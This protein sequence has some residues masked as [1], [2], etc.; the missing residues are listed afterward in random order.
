MASVSL[1]QPAEASPTRTEFRALVALALPLA[2]A[3]LIQMMVYAV[4]VIFVARLGAENL[5]ASSLS[6]SLFGLLMWSMTGLVGAAA[7]LI[8]AELGRRRHAVREV[9]RSMRMGMWLAVIA[10]LGVMAICAFGERIMLLTGQ[11]PRVAALAGGFLWILMWAAI[12]NIAAALL[13]VFVSALGRPGIAIAI[14][15][16]ALAVN[17]VG[18]YAFVF[19]NLGAPALGL[20]GSAIS[21]V[22][23]T[24]AMLA[25]YVAV[26][27]TDRRFRR[28]R[29]FG[30]WWRSDWARFRDMLAI[31]VPITG[32]ILAEAGLFCG[33]A[34][35]MGRIG[36]AELAGHTIALQFAALAFQVPFGI[37]QAATIRVG[38]HYGAGDRDGI[39]HAGNAAIVLGIGFM[40]LTGLT[41]WLFPRAILHLY[42]DPDA[43]VNAGLVGFALQYLV[44][45]AAFQLFDGAQAV[46]AGSLR[47]LQDTRVPMAIALFGY[48]LPGFGTAIV[49]GFYT[50]LKGLGIWIGLA[51]GLIVVASGLLW[52][53]QSRERLG[54][55]PG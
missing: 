42:V 55:L 46:A 25:A 47:G 26:I 21:S 31:G 15:V 2:G 39:A 44:V 34:F 23:T 1:P 30:R 54:L 41:I 11:Q 9:R 24:L 6:V 27:L 22:I 18:N 4:D 7:P 49:L 32:T 51:V 3:N 53:W 38:Y 40:A 35:L 28:Y 12:P 13:R 17:T 19:G 14:T 45:A 20:N 36:E 10:G 50:P 29:L 37:A 43:A 5:A 16:L 48:W 52:R 33:A 8:A